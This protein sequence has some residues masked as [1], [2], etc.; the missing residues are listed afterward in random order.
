M[1]RWDGEP[2]ILLVGRDMTDRRR[3]ESSLDRMRRLQALGTLTGG[4][5]HD[6]NN[7]LTGIIGRLSL[8][9]GLDNVDAAARTQITQALDAADSARRLVTRLMRFSRP[10]G[11]GREPTDV[12][13]LVRDSESLLRSLVREE[14][15]L[16][17]HLPSTPLYAEVEAASIQEILLNLAKNADD[18]CA[19]TAGVLLFTV[20]VSVDDGV[21]S[22]Q[23]LVTDTGPGMPAQVQERIF[24]PFFT[25][26]AI[27]H[28]HG[29]GL[30]LAHQIMHEQDG[31][32]DAESEPGQGT[33]FTLTLPLCEAPAGGPMAPPDLALAEGKGRRILVVDDEPDVLDTTS[34]MLARLGYRVYRAT[35]GREALEIVDAD[36]PFDA[37]LLDMVM[38]EMNG[39]ECA[40][41]LEDR[42]DRTPIIFMSGYDPDP[43]RMRRLGITRLMLAKPFR[44]RVLADTIK[45]QIAAG[46]AAA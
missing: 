27:G 21:E 44:L 19:G 25:T 18:A 13:Q 39:F 40:S 15:R 34:E 26:K 41:A 32:I 24:E 31:T 28:G 38:P 12:V 45:E 37:I 8:L 36:G 6:F 1:A 17:W 46:Q 23:I 43:E 22:V 35:N 10:E 33:T 5:A 11:T 7:Y 16:Q 20:R 42:G 9:E 4:I 29:L 3:L 30:A 14:L 2:A